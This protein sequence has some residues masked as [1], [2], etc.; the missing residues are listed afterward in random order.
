MKIA[1]HIHMHVK[2]LA[3]IG[4]AAVAMA[5]VPAQAQLQLGNSP[6]RLQIGNGKALLGPD[7]PVAPIG[8]SILSSEVG[9]AKDAG[10]SVRLLGPD[11][12]FGVYTTLLK[13][14]E[15]NGTSVKLSTPLDSM[16]SPVSTK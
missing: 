14:N 11:K 12:T 7:E 2:A 5:S 9:A 16:L 8:I 4:G 1:S 10:T 13:T 15:K 6:I 3:L